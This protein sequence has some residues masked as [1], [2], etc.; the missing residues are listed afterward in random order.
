MSNVLS[1]NCSIEVE[2]NI[3]KYFIELI[4]RVVQCDDKSTR[5]MKGGLIIRTGVDVC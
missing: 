4:D 2:N 3:N 5:G 1:I